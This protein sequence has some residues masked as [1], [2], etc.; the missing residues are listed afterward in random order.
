ML[1]IV[2]FFS[3]FTSVMKK[4]RTSRATYVNM[5]V[6]NSSVTYT[7]TTK[8]VPCPVAIKVRAAQ[9]AN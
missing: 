5:K 2:T 1:Q 4:L 6:T 9:K 3:K 7:N 8:T